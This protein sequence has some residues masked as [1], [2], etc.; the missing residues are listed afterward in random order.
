MTKPTGSR[1]R[2]DEASELE[3]TRRELR[4]AQAALMHSE[5]MAV[6]GNLLAGVAHEI[7]TP[8]GSINSNTDVALRALD[9]LREA[10]EKLSPE[11]RDDP[12]LKNAVDILQS[13]G[14]VN[15]T[16]C[17]RIV[18]LVRSLR[19]FARLETVEPK[20]ADLHEG[21]ESTLTLA[22][23]VLK[24]RVEVVREYGKIPK[25]ECY[26]DQLNQVF[27]NILVN[28][29]HAIE[30]SGKITIRTRTDG[31]DVIITFTDTGK[32]IAPEDLPR[33]FD[34]GFTTKGVGVGS[35]LGL[36]ICYKIINEHGGGIDVESELGRGTTV[37]VRLP[38]KAPERAEPGEI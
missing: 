33:I 14:N 18:K 15:K 23:H 4:D 25:V 35:G 34:P 38:L 20:P 21:L 26:P 37:T 2:S 9:K 7:N 12:D 10:L 8:I 16:A 19:N 1:S 11:V 3:S 13:V 36:P 22:Y 31:D 27:L 6:L 17:D 32:G 5:K 30:R 28:A 29:A 24:N